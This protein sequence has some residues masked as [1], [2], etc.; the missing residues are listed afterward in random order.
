MAR[1]GAMFVG[2]VIVAVLLAGDLRGDRAP[3]KGDGPDAKIGLVDLKAVFEKLESFKEQ[4]EALKREVAARERELKPL[5]AELLEKLEAFKKLPPDQQQARKDEILELQ[6]A[7]KT[8][9]DVEKLVFVKKEADMYD[10]HYQRIVEE[11]GRQAERR[12]LS[13]VFRI[14]DTSFDEAPAGEKRTPEQ[15][16]KVLNRSVVYHRPEVNLTNDVVDALNGR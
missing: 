15:V 9:F 14:G 8:K 12:G 16:L 11:I 10:A 1:Y 5:S 4:S 3:G 2:G 7:F 13:V 6:K